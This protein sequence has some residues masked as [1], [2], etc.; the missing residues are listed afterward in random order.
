VSS[1]RPR[2]CVFVVAVGTLLAAVGS[3]LAGTISG[4]PKGDTLRGTPKADTLDG[5][6]GNDK[7]YG[8]G[9]KDRLV[10][11]AGADRLEGGPASDV[12]NCGPGRDVAVADPSDRVGKDC[13]KVTGRANASPPPP[14]PPQPPAGTPPPP[15]AGS[16]GGSTSQGKPISLV[17]SADGKTVVEVELEYRATC[18]PNGNYAGNVSTATTVAIQPDRSFTASVPTMPLGTSAGSIN[19]KFDA[20]GNVSGTLAARPAVEVGGRRIECDTGSVTWTASRR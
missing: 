18:G 4:T 16:Y 6:A 1:A 9:G 3:G 2:T 14:P 7:L 11:G 5:R 10:G 15:A 8:M 12:L 13:E 19:G 17:V 20:A